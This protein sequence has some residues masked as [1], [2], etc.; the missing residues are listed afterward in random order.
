MKNK[1]KKH[2]LTGSIS[3][4]ITQR[5]HI[6]IRPEAFQWTIKGQSFESFFFLL[7]LLNK[8]KINMENIFFLFCFF[9]FFF[10]HQ[11]A[12]CW[13]PAT[14][15]KPRKYFKPAST[16]FYRYISSD[17]IQIFIVIV[18]K[19]NSNSFPSM[20]IHTHKKKNNLQTSERNFIPPF[21][22]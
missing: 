12:K 11:L 4:V 10:N 22:N 5:T 21:F 18:I 8:H 2:F 13:Q 6:I 3:F 16:I 17:F 19:Q 1:K 9:F 14:I 20:L 15:F 7:Y